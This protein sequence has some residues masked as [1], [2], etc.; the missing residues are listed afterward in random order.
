VSGHWAARLPSYQTCT[1]NVADLCGRPARE[2]LL[3]SDDGIT[4]AGRPRCQQHPAQE[5][6]DLLLHFA[7]HV[8]WIIVPYPVTADTAPQVTAIL[9]EDG[10]DSGQTVLVTPRPRPAGGSL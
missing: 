5:S 10:R 9:G 2:L 1:F 8:F 6:V 7:P 3:V 4:W